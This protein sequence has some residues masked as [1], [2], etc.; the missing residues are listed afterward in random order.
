MAGVAGDSMSEERTPSRCLSGTRGKC[1]RDFDENF[2]GP[3]FAEPEIDLSRGR[4]CAMIE[5]VSF[6]ES[7]KHGPILVALG[8][9]GL[10][11]IRER[12]QIALG[13]I[14]QAE[15]G[16]ALPKFR[17]GINAAHAGHDIDAQ[18]D[19]L[20]VSA[21]KVKGVAFPQKFDGEGGHGDEFG[22]QLGESFFSTGPDLPDWQGWRS[23]CRG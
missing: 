13:A 21:T 18:T 17:K 15:R 14:G 16:A 20:G 23:R 2:G 6:D 10:N 5:V 7:A 1:L 9:L 22:L 12:E 11:Q 8:F 19:R 3:K 4:L